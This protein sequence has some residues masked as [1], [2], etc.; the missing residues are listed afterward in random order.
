[1]KKYIRLIPVAAL[2]LLLSA[3]GKTDEEKRAESAIQAQALGCISQEQALTYKTVYSPEIDHTIQVCL[4]QERNV[5]SQIRQEQRHQETMVYYE[6]EMLDELDDITEN[7]AYTTSRPISPIEPGE[8]YSRIGD[9]DCGYWIGGRWEWYDEDSICANQNRRYYDY[10]V[11]TGALAASELYRVRNYG[12]YNSWKSR[13]NYRGHVVVDNYY[14]RS[15][16]IISPSIFKTQRTDY[17]SQRNS[18]SSNRNT[19]RQSDTYKTAFVQAKSKDTRYDNKTVQSRVTA[20]KSGT[21]KASDKPKFTS[22]FAQGKNKNTQAGTVVNNGN[23]T[24][25]R[26]NG[27][28]SQTSSTNKKDVKPTNFKSQFAQGS[29][30]N[31]AQA[32][33]TVKP[34]GSATVQTQQQNSVKPKK[35]TEFKSQFAKSDRKK[36]A[37]TTSTGNKGTNKSASNNSGRKTTST[38]SSSSKKPKKPKKKK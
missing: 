16:K 13:P 1:M 18:W 37:S 27:T 9:D 6:A 22:Q 24:Q 30:K 14:G 28:V 3:C 38:S 35:P 23:T 31:T 7:L 10:M 36:P 11:I 21:F 4:Q 20:V 19:F 33:T 8:Y 34:N 17:Y 15:G 26:T 12:Y 32:Q 25:S 29:N 5:K 2:T